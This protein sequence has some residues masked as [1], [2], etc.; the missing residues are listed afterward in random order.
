MN[1][2]EPPEQ[3]G[4][5]SFDEMVNLDEWQP[6]EDFFG[7]VGDLITHDVTEAVDLRRRLREELLEDDPGIEGK[8]QRCSAEMLTWAKAELFGG[9][10]CAVDGTISR[11][12]SLSGG[13]ARIG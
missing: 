6:V 8:V 5:P 2:H 10:V 7:K 3:K 1:N 9:R 13:R 11:S 12:P 4:P